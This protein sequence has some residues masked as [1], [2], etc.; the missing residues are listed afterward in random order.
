MCSIGWESGNALKI[1]VVK[2]IEKEYLEDVRQDTRFELIG[3]IKHLKLITTN[4]YD[5]VA[6][7]HTLRITIAHA[8]SQII[9]VLTGHC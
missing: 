5:T 6:Y 2:L 1:A 4:N 8:T 9:R 7:V 3:F